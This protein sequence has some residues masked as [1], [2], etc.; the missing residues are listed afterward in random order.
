MDRPTI[1]GAAGRAA[2]MR[3]FALGLVVGA[4]AALLSLL[5]AGPVELALFRGAIEVSSAAVHL[6]LL[7]GGGV[8]GWVLRDEFG[9]ADVPP[10]RR[11]P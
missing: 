6:A 1:V 7:A 3:P 8:I 10:D 4:G 5:H 11:R 2:A 9:R